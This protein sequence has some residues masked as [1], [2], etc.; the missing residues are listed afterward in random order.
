MINNIILK[1]LKAF[2]AES[3]LVE[4]ELLRNHTTFKV[5]GKADAFLSVQ[6]EGQLKTVVMYLKKHKIPY[7]V[8]GN[9]SNLLVSDD[10]FRGVILSIGRDFSKIVIEGD[11]ITAEAG[12]LLSLVA[13]KAQE[14]SLTGMEFA[15]GIPGSIGGAIVMNAGAYG[16][17][18]KQIVESV[19]VLNELGQ[20]I[21]YS[22]EEMEF[23][24]RNSRIK[25]ENSIVVSVT[26]S[27]KKGK[28]DEIL[29]KTKDFASRRREKQPLEYPSAG[30]TFKRPEGNF[31]GK[32]VMEAGLAG[33]SV[34]DAEVSRKHCGFVINKGNATANEIYTLICEVQ[35]IVKDKYSV[36]L[37][38]EV[39]F[40]GNMENR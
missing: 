4:G 17:E 13:H 30:S 27:L 34:G 39:I 12:A 10:G 19:T 9:G 5:G 18:M 15:S 11:K 31:A 7:Y 3:T 21:I 22:V 33:Y 23:A 29:E 36:S 32:L 20:R 25:K 2:A 1:D 16:G 14:H 8:I 35:R 38:P 6:S 24:Y 26:L 37:E 40:L 28:L